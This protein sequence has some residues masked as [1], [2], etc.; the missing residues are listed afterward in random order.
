MAIKIRKMNNKEFDAFYQWSVEHHAKELMEE[1]HMS[2][3]KAIKETKK[4]VA[5]MLPDGLNT[6]NNCLMTIEEN[7]NKEII[8]FIW[9]IHEETEGK[10]QSFLCDFVILESKRRKGYATAAL[11]LAEKDAAEAGCQ[12]S[13]LFVADRNYAASALYEKCGY[14]FLRQENYGKY[15][16]K[17]LY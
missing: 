5:Q 15:M 11:Q 16:T 1:C 3:K 7:D 10:K 12:V 2:Q 17:Q 6:E 8:G 14:K 9:T 13:V 4:E